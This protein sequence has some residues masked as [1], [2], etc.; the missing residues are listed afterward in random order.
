MSEIII[1]GIQ[2]IG[3]GV[4]NVYE[5]WEWYRK[6][7]GMDLAVFDEA[8]Q[9]ELMLPY[10]EGEPRSRHA[11]LALNYRGGSGLE[12]WQYTSRTP[13]PADFSI[14]LGD[15]GILAIKYKCPNIKETYRDLKEKGVDIVSHLGIE[16]S[17]KSFFARD[18]FGNL[19]EMVE[20]NYW[21]KET[22]GNGGVFGCIIGVSDMNKSVEFYEN[23]LGY[24][25]V[26][27]EQIS[28]FNDFNAIDKTSFK[29]ERVILSHVNKRT[30][31]FADL[32]GPSEIELVK[33]VNRKPKK[34]Y[35]NRMW[36][37]L[38]YIHL[39]FDVWGM[40][41]LKEK[42]ALRNHPFTVDSANSFDMGEAAGRFT[43]TEDPDGTLI[44]FVETHKIPIMKKLGWYFDLRNRN[45]HKS[46]P[47]Y[48]LK[49]MFLNR[50][51]KPVYPR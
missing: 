37:D 12:I 11:V 50:S 30:G 20:D 6:N 14:Q 27:Y 35:Q 13:R 43:Y 39:C 25:E 21:F 38:G 10:T 41:A 7:L 1:S 3:I 2:Q 23:Y 49:A 15:L 34:V 46:L 8:A 48:M 28:V 42:A 45:H 47:K 33:V 17:R 31:P 18:S 36:G 40:D 26:K 29:Y 44:E 24:N 9:A 5:A 32:F 51:K 4:S 16:N 22:S 19:F